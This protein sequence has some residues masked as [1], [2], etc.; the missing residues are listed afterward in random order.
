MRWSLALSFALAGCVFELAPLSSGTGGA[1]GE[2]GGGGSGAGAVG[3]ELPIAYA[4]GTFSS[5]LSDV[6]VLVA[7]DATRIDYDLAAADGSDLRAFDANGNVLPLEI[8][9][10][11]PGGSSVVWVRLG[12]LSSGGGSFSLRFGDPNASAG[13]GAD[14]LWSDY[15]ALY[16]F[17]DADPAAQVADALGNHHGVGN[18]PTREPALIGSGL[19]FDGVSAWVDVGNAP[20]WEV[21]PQEAKT[22]SIWFQRDTVPGEA[23]RSMVTMRAR[24]AV[25]CQGWQMTVLGDAFANTN[26]ATHMNGCDIS[27]F[28]TSNPGLGDYDDENWHHF[29]AVFDRINGQLRMY[30]DAELRAEGTLD[31]DAAF[32]SGE[33]AF[34]IAEVGDAPFAGLLDEARIRNE[35][36][37]Q[38]WLDASLTI[39]RDQALTF[40]TIV[41]RS[42]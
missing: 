6:P 20:G 9:S 15:S 30:I 21:G 40:G 28:L 13:P 37:D 18:G 1:G 31:T 33:A 4:S 23:M 36:V 22:A 16:H 5:D 32:V 42:P 26:I 7:L 24:R 41:Q 34:G 2:T 14:T 29:V 35:A 17:A 25:G 3:Y 39:G 12:S 10:W 27:S 11:V 8:E 19:G 38:A